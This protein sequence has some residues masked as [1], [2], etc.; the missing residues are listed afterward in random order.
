MSGHSKWNSIK[1]KKGAADAKRGKIFTKHAK[2]IFI[3]ARDG[4]VDPDMNAALRAAIINAK[5][6]NVPNANIDKALKKASG[7]GK[8]AVIL[9][10]GMYE[11][12][13]PAGTALCVE[14]I[15]DN[16]NRSFTN[17]KNIFSKTG[18]NLGESG[19]VGWMFERKGV[20]LAK[21]S[22]KDTDEAELQ[23]I[24]AG[25]EDLNIDGAEFEIITDPSQLMSVRDKLEASGFDVEKAE[26]SYLPKDAIKI[27][28][29]DDARKIFRLMD[30]LDDD[31]DVSNIYSNFDISDEIMESI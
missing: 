27:D 17:V 10:E 16:K 3:A 8:D 25:A 31:E 22:G 1:Y 18:G 23:A 6:D 5:S 26:L 11:G 7:D 30:A 2:F 24:D 29:A 9:E 4:G 13:G 20:I 12:F 15:T 28:N 19:S 14:V 21:A